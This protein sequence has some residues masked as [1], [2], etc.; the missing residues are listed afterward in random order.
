M[1][2]KIEKMKD[3]FAYYCKGSYCT[4]LA[5]STMIC[6]SK[7]CPFYKT[8]TEYEKGGVTRWGNQLMVKGN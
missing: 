4:C 2:E 6:E 7:Q 5:L 8:L 1:E 3:C